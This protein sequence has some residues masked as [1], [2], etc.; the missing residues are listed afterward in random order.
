MQERRL[1]IQ[2]N[3][4]AVQFQSNPDPYQAE[5]IANAVAYI[6]PKRIS[7][8]I[9]G[10]AAKVVDA[11]VAASSP[12]SPS[13]TKNTM[14]GLVI[15]C[16]LSVMIIVLREIFD[17]S[18]RVEEDIARG[19]SYPVLATV[20]NMAAPSKGGYYYGSYGRSKKKPAAA[21]T[22]KK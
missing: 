19:T 9:D 12:S 14:L 2:R 3:L 4:T 18:I 22:N 7:T 16:L 21:D 1:R 13:Y 15:G 5:Q 11:A 10:S 17:I 20:P 6:L 8:I